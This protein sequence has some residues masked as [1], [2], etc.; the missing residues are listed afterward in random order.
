M[1]AVSSSLSTAAP[2][3]VFPAK[4][5]PSRQS[6]S[7][8]LVAA[9]G[10]TIRTFGS[11]SLHL[12]FPGLHTSQSFHLADV[13]KPILGANFISKHGLLIDLQGRRLLRL[14]PDDSSLLAPLATVAASASTDPPVDVCGL[15]LP[16][17]NKVEEL[18]DDF[19]GVL[20]S[21]YDPAALPAHGVKHTVPTTGPPVYARARRLMGD[22]LA[23]AKAEFQKMLDLKI[24]QPSKSA[25]AS[26]LH[27]VPKP[28][29]TWRP[30]GDYR[31]LN[32]AT[33]DDRYPLPHIHSFTTATAG[34]SF[35]S[36]ID[37]VRGYHQIPM[38]PADVEKTAIITPF[39]LY[40]FLRMPFGLKNS[41]QAF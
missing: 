22:K 28:N 30:C 2:T 39:G 11:K 35:F 27:V 24:I 29:G 20:V 5:T 34:A 16:R 8:N 41:A 14:P 40:E 15:H 7:S 33:V 19:P 18:L 13:R 12:K 4:G 1:P 36:V 25:W 31:R 37:L 21:H 9:N 23:A 6:L 26:P 32:L 10:S 38:D 3:C 17:Q